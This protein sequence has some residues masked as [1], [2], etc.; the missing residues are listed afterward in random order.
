V[1]NKFIKTFMGVSLLASF[2]LAQDPPAAAAPK[3]AKDQIEFGLMT[4]LNKEADP[5]KKLPILDQWTEKYPDTVFKQERNYYYIDAYSK[6]ISKGLQASAPADAVEAAQKAA[7]TLIDKADAFF[8]SENKLPSATDDQWAQAK[9]QVLLQAHGALVTI[10]TNKKDFPTAEA[11]Y[12]KLIAMDEGNALMYSSLAGLIM[13]ERN[14]ARYPDAIYLYARAISLAGPGAIKDDATKKSLTDYLVRIYNNYHGG[15]DGLDDVKAKAVTAPYPPADF[16]IKSV[17]EISM[18]A[19][20]NADAFAK[21]FPEILVWR[22]V[23]EQL[24]GAGGDEYFKSNMKEAEVAGL[25]GKV[26]SQNGQKELLLSM[27]YATPETEKK[28]ELTLK[29]ETPLKGNVDP[30]S[31]LTFAAVPESFTKDPFMVVVTAEKAKVDGLGDAA[32]APETKKVA[33][34]KKAPTATKKKTGQ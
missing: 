21:A 20:S 28:A 18:E 19:N 11:E 26:V 1:L 2:A 17:T 4:D 30:G 23:K 13:S 3:T 24:T 5:S 31:I 6:I 7:Q 9:K 22:G 12:K 15:P 27:D 25:K 8:S 33:P 29:F 32:G 14:V 16:H 10:A 34:K